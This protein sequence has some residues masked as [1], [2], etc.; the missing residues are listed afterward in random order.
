MTEMRKYIDILNEQNQLV[1][2]PIQV[3]DTVIYK[4]HQ[5]EVVG[6]NPRDFGELLLRK[7]EWEGWVRDDDVQRQTVENAQFDYGDMLRKVFAL[8][9]KYDISPH[10]TTNWW[11]I[12]ENR[13]K[14]AAKM[15]DE[16]YAEWERLNKEIE[17][18]KPPMK[19]IHKRPIGSRFD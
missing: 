17:A 14:V 12:E 3:G 19:N 2:T 15:S 9:D 10:Q 8:Q 18:N 16:D 1:E 13:A 6:V 5:V 11:K 7:G 4:G